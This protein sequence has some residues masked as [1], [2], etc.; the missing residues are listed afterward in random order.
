VR[1]ILGQQIAVTA[2]TRLAGAL[3]AA[4]GEPLDPELAR[5]RLTHV[6]PSPQALAGADLSRLGMPRARAR[7]ISALAALAAASPHLFEPGPDLEAAA[8]RLRALPGVG[9]WT[10]H[11]VAMR[12]LREPDAFPA[13]DVGL[14]R[15]LADARGVR[16]SPQVLL[17]RAEAWRPWRA[18]AALH[19]WTADAAA[20]S[21]R[22]P[23]HAE[24]RA[25]GLRRAGVR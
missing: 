21:A 11:Y 14:Q 4:H 22:S 15:A 17:A 3:V 10:A 9:E 5:A 23:A 18:Y 24:P 25:R 19:L 2:A 13:G 7:S 6:F 8:E 1:A 20:T 16:P 12:A